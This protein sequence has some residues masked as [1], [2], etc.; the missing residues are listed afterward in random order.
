MKINCHLL[1]L[2]TILVAI[3][4]LGADRKKSKS[5]T[6]VK[7]RNEVEENW[8]RQYASYSR[9]KSDDTPRESTRV[10]IQDK[11]QAGPPERRKSETA[12]RSFQYEPPTWVTP[13]SLPPHP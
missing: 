4:L 12:R 6:S 2:A 13:T 3:C 5:E 1:T 8:T 10:R 9:S 11:D 7:H